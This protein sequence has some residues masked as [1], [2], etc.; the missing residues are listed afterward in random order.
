MNKWTLR[1][2]RLCLCRVE[3]IEN[4]GILAGRF[5][6]G[7][8]FRLLRGIRLGTVP[9]AEMSCPPGAEHQRRLAQESIRRGTENDGRPIRQL[10][11]E[12]VET[13]DRYGLKARH[14]GKH[15]RPAEGFIDY[16]AGL[17]CATEVARARQKRIEKT[18]TNFSHS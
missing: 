10:L 15:R 3:R 17:D 4:P 11:R 6:G 14:L 1:E 13:V 9:S 5:Q 16:V 2:R 18:G 7:S 12:I 8:R